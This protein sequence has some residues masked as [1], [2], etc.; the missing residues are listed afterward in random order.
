MILANKIIENRKK[1]GWSQEELAVKLDVSRQSVSKW[2]GAQAIPDMKKIIQMAELFGVTT[3]YLLRDDIEEEVI[4]VT[5]SVD[6]DQED[7]AVRVSMEEANRFLQYNEKAASPISIGVLLCITSAVPLLLLLALSHANYLSISEYTATMIGMVMI[8]IMVA[9]A[10]TIF[11]LVNAKGKSFKYL[12]EKDIDTDYG[13]SGMAKEG[14]SKYEGIYTRSMVIGVVLCIVSATPLFILT[15]NNYTTT[16][17]LTLSGVAALLIMVGV[18]VKILVK[19]AMINNGYNKLLEEGEYTRLNKRSYRWDSIY[20]SIAAAIYLAWSFISGR[21]DFTWIVW[22]IAGVT[23]AA[24][25]E[26]I[27][28]IIRTKY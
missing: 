12:E 15:I 10:V 2:E 3:D 14:R 28:T 8:L 17:S 13:V 25:K 22:P 9:S 27:K 19:T 24:Y 7:T 18:G 11:I 6:Y 1:N 26:I 16:N 21:W 5:S 23:F 20:W 4:P